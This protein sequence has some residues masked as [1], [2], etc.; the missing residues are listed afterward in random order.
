M[1]R[2]RLVVIILILC[3]VVLGSPR[4]LQ[5]RTSSATIGNCPIFPPDNPWNRDVSTDPV[6]PN[7]D[8]YIATLNSGNN[9]FLRAGFGWWAAYGIPYVVVPGN[10]PKVP[11]TFNMWGAQSDPGPYP[12][13]PDA[14]VEGDGQVYSDQHVVVIDKDNCMLYE[15]Y[16]A[17]FNGEGWDAGSGA[18]FNLRSNDLRPEGWTS[19]DAAGLPI[20]PGLAR[21]EEVRTGAITHALR[22]TA[23]GGQTQ[24]KFIYPA[25]HYQSPSTNPNLAPMGLR[26]RLKASFD[27][28]RYTSD[29]RIILE[30]LKKY[31]MFVADEG[32]SWYISGMSSPQWDRVSLETLQTVPGSAFEVVQPDYST[33]PRSDIIFAPVPFL[34]PQ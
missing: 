16:K 9:A 14:P 5:A 29:A 4:Q 3:A 18:I 28:S 33:P 21:V 8:N 20:F 26:V 11:I 19:A 31:G 25:R 24:K 34:R 10:Q 15:L 30:A 1:V 6:D 27:I 2:S 7:S 17:S 23:G 32:G 22:F 13:P 12:I